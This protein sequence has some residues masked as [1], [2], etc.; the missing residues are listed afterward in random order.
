[1]KKITFTDDSYIEKVN[2]GLMYIGIIAN[3][4]GHILR[5]AGTDKLEYIVMGLAGVK[6]GSLIIKSTI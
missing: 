2:A 3:E 6:N 1:M 4:F 5:R